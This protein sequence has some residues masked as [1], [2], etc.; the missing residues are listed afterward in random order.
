MQVSKLPFVTAIS[1]SHCI[2]VIYVSTHY[3]RAIV[4]LTFGFNLAVNQF[5]EPPFSFPLPLDLAS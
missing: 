3:I 4:V 5:G 2:L 1:E